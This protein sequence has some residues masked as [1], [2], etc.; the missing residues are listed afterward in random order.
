M[1]DAS[2]KEDPRQSLVQSLFCKGIDTHRSLMPSMIDPNQ[3]H[4]QGNVFERE[5]TPVTESFDNGI[6]DAKR[7]QRDHEIG[8]LLQSR[9]AEVG[10]Y[11]PRTP[12][13]LK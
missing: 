4:F 1:V 3:S 9:K 10:R 12:M 2:R 5:S 13:A 6:G 8:E 7:G 11:L